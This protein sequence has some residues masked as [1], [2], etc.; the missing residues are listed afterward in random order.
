MNK[1]IKLRTSADLGTDVTSFETDPEEK[2]E[3]RTS[4]HWLGNFVDLKIGFELP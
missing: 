4:F 3:L 1:Y 2:C